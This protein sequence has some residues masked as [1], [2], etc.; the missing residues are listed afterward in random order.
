MK[1][2]DEKEP[3]KVERVVRARKWWTE[4]HTKRGGGC[5]FH[6]VSFQE[7]SCS[8]NWRSNPYFLTSII[9]GLRGSRKGG[10]SE[11]N[12]EMWFRCEIK[13]WVETRGKRGEEN[14]YKTQRKVD[15]QKLLTTLKKGFFNFQL[16]RRKRNKR[17]SRYVNA[18][19][20]H[21]QNDIRYFAVH[22][23]PGT[24]VRQNRSWHIS[25]HLYPHFT[26]YSFF[27]HH[28]FVH[29]YLIQK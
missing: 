14:V 20:L 26:K 5:F 25:I 17:C 6:L 2:E 11:K 4:E 28:P 1:I 7:E 27:T 22:P 3:G 9:H 8:V 16:L 21:W 12:M 18:V 19:Q 10:K 15:D 23:H 24:W 13:S 29:S